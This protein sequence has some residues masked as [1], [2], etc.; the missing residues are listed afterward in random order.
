LD[1]PLRFS[2]DP[3]GPGA[4]LSDQFLLLDVGG[5]A[6]GLSDGKQEPKAPMPTTCHP[7]GPAAMSLFIIGCVETLD[8][9]SEEA[10]KR[11]A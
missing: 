8:S 6:K 11:S 9:E 5:M 3:E 4:S 1:L 2:V 7:I 10:P